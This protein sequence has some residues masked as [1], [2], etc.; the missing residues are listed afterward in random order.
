M[1]DAGSG[2]SDMPGAGGG[3]GAPGGAG[4]SVGGSTGTGGA[5]PAPVMTGLHVDGNTIKNGA[6]QVVRLRGVNRSGTEYKCVQTGTTIFDGAADAASIQVIKSWNVNAVRI[7]L[8]ESCW[9][10]ING[11]TA[12]KAGDNYRNAIR[13]YVMLLEQANLAP[14]LELHWV[15]P[16]TTLAQRQQPMPSDHSVDFWADVAAAFASDPYVVF[17]P[18]NEPFP[19]M[20]RDSAA[21]WSCWRDGCA[22]PLQTA[23]GTSG[24]YQAAGFQALV[25]A[26]RG[27]GSPALI[28]LGGVQ[29]SNRLTMWSASKPTDAMNNLAAA[30]HVYNFNG[31]ATASCWNGAPATL[32]AT[33]P[34]VATEFGENDCQATFVNT[35]IDWMNGKGLSFLAWTWDT[36]GACTPG[37]TNGQGGNPWALVSAYT[38]ATPNSAYAQA[39]HDKFT[40]LTP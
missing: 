36:W 6:G 40:A 37:M 38:S 32:A 25:N 7:P 22:A 11:A 8:N 24:T 34:I 27:A 33:V 20:N 31:C 29:Y 4:G 26:I 17:E 28:L 1:G 21:A 5:G 39:V 3:A 14:I 9:L 16:G 35:F 12:A 2:G 15:G 10:A 18:Y 19:D 23:S 30:W 13:D